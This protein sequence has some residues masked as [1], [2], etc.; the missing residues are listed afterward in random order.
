MS[1]PVWEQ[2]FM[3]AGADLKQWNIRLGNDLLDH[4]DQP[5]FPG[6]GNG[7]L[8]YYTDRPGNL[9]LDESGLHIRACLEE[10]EHEGRSFAY[11]SARLD[12]RDRFSFRYGKLVV[13]AKLPVGQGLW[14][15]IWLMPQ[16]QAYGPWPA[17]GELDM[18]E[19]KGRL[20][21]QIAGTLHYGKD[22][23]SK[24]VE[25]FTY[26]LPEGTINEFRDY[27]LEWRAD[28]IRWL[29]DGHCFAERRLEPG[30]MPF[31]QRFYLLLNLAVGGWYDNGAEVDESALPG[32]MTV[33]GIWLYE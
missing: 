17:S 30:V 32:V 14:P 21:K 5:V 18:L 4:N 8:Q 27:G 24:I 2:N 15:A 7:E 12:T 13:R 22:I 16:D 6:W 20:P 26:E 1:K 23:E 10:V 31:D 11:T 29:V 3:Q 19:A 25:E 28:S 33:E 9:C